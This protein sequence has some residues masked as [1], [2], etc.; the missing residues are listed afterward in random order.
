[1]AKGGCRVTLVLSTLVKKKK[2]KK[3]VKNLN[4]HP[5]I[6]ELRYL[7]KNYWNILRHVHIFNSQELHLSSVITVIQEQNVEATFDI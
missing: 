2:K 6:I 5:K 1:M 4:S 3:I 7:T